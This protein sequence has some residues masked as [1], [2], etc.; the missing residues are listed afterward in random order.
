MLVAGKPAV[1]G[2]SISLVVIGMG[3]VT[4]SVP[5]CPQIDLLTACFSYVI[6]FAGMK[7]AKAGK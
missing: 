5:V 4:A 1:S 7:K 2:G 6:N 3:P